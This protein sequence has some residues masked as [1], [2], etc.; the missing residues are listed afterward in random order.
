PRIW[1]LFRFQKKPTE[2]WLPPLMPNRNR[3][4]I[5][6]GALLVGRALFAPALSFSAEPQLVAA[7]PREHTRLETDWLF[8]LGDVTARDEVI[9]PNFDDRSWQRVQ[10]PH[11]YV[12]EGNYYLPEIPEDQLK[13]RPVR[14]H[15][16]LPH[17]VGWYRRR[18]LIP[19]SARGKILR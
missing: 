7:S 10:L 2:I 18:L 12:R 5:I 1:D 4:L 9:A 11:D 15:G 13:V 19:E 3:G 14:N 6:V 17:G 16:Y 8:H